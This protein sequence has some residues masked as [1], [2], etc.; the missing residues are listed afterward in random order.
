MSWL[1]RTQGT[2]IH[3]SIEKANTVTG[4][5]VYRSSEQSIKA[6]AT[7]PN[8]VTK[9][10]NLGKSY[11]CHIKDSN[12]LKTIP[13]YKDI[14]GVLPTY[15]SCYIALTGNDYIATY[16]DGVFK[17]TSYA[18]DGVGQNTPQVLIRE[19]VGN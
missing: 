19:V 11:G 18:S 12:E 17:I 3:W 5:N 10:F 13:L 16:N 6:E 4:T 15:V 7:F 2:D 8:G 14:K 9:R 1:Y